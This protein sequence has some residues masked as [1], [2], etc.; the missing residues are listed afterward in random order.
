[1]VQSLEPEGFTTDGLPDEPV[2][3]RF[4][5]STCNLPSGM[6]GGIR[7]GVCDR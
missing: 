7:A 5:S 6:L 1:M 3:D 2:R 4:A